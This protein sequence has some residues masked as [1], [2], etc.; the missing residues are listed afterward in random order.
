MLCNSTDI[1]A[2]LCVCVRVQ[3]VCAYECVC[4]F[5]CYLGAGVF[6]YSMLF[7]FL[8]PIQGR[9]VIRW[10]PFEVQLGNVIGLPIHAIRLHTLQ[11]WH[12]C[13]LTHSLLFMPLNRSECI[14]QRTKTVEFGWCW[15]V[16]YTTGGNHKKNVADLMNIMHL[17]V[18]SLPFINHIF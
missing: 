5:V 2:S 7:S 17:Y 12:A 16:N 11:H 13:S 10:A 18:L 14:S 6:R 15:L 1:S 9:V 8:E 4:M 3:S